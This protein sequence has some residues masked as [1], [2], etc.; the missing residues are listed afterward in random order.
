M[1]DASAHNTSRQDLSTTG[2]QQTQQLL[3][4]C[5][6]LLEACSGASGGDAAQLQQ[7][8]EQYL[9]VAAALRQTLEQCRDLDVAAAASADASTSG[10][11][12][13]SGCGQCS[14]HQLLSV[15]L[16]MMH[17][18]LLVRPTVQ[19]YLPRGLVA[20]AKLGRLVSA[21]LAAAAAGHCPGPIGP[22]LPRLPPLSLLA[23]HAQR[24]TSRTPR[25]SSCV[26]APR[27]CGCAWRR[28]TS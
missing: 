13:R 11:G 27:S 25:C 21:M 15:L 16:N 5:Q 20:L 18:Y 23:F 22:P 2:Q 8:Q 26:R 24:R 9:S 12:C 14:A 28:R 6:Q 1:Q 10:G 7:L 4:T 17:C 19:L 3:A